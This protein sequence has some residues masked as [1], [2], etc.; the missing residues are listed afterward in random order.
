MYYFFSKLAKL[1]SIITYRISTE[2]EVFLR[3]IDPCTENT[4][5]PRARSARGVS[6]SVHGFILL[7]KAECEVDIRLTYRLT[8]C[9]VS[10][11]K[12]SFWRDLRIDKVRIII[13]PIQFRIFNFLSLSLSL[14]L[15]CLPVCLPLSV[16]VFVR[17]SVCL[18][19]CRSVSL[20]VSSKIFML[21]SWRWNSQ[22]KGKVT[23][24]L[25]WIHNDL[26][27]L[28]QSWLLYKSM[29]WVKYFNEH[30]IHEVYSVYIRNKICLNYT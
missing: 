13:F 26:S 7:R 2:Y 21:S 11:W 8:Q 9:A 30:Y 18:S 10:L 22:I 14:S 1:R 12:K 23:R 16:S 5:T 17:L 28:M 24:Y 19:V 4:G 20:A 3:N 29:V 15:F 25:V 27:E 6:F